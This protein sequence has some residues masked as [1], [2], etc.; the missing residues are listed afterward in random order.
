[1]KYLL[2]LLLLLAPSLA[3][4]APA[5]SGVTGT[6]THGISIVIGGSGSGTCDHIQSWTVEGVG[7]WLGNFG[8]GVL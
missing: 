2:S 8:L 6:V 3:E 1:M 5:V 4:A 7:G